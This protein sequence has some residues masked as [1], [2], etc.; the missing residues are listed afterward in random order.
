MSLYKFLRK[1]L[2]ERFHHQL[3]GV[4]DPVDH[5]VDETVITSSNNSKFTK[6]AAPFSFEESSFILSPRIL[7]T[8][9]CLQMK[10]CFYY[11]QSLL[12]PQADYTPKEQHFKF[13]T[14]L[15]FERMY[16]GF[17]VIFFLHYFYLL[18][19]VM[20]RSSMSHESSKRRPGH[21]YHNPERKELLLTLDEVSEEDGEE[22]WGEGVEEDEDEDILGREFHLVHLTPSPSCRKGPPLSSVATA[23]TMDAFSLLEDSDDEN[24]TSSSSEYSFPSRYAAA[25]W[26]YHQPELMQQQHSIEGYR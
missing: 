22:D 23:T 10:Q 14:T 18:R 2:D 16:V 6:S 20:S 7:A 4:N 26:Y 5:V 12:F 19:I 9:A 25:D 3:L 1:T 21:H 8:N 11:L 15:D 17:A 13:R 24:S